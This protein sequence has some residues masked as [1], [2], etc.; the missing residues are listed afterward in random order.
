MFRTFKAFQKS[1]RSTHLA[2]VVKYIIVTIGQF[3]GTCVPLLRAG[4]N[5]KKV[6]L[7]PLMRYIMESY[8]NDPTHCTNRKGYVRTQGDALAQIQEWM[9]YQAYMKRIRNFAV[10]NPTSLL[11]DGDANK[12]TAKRI[13]QLWSAGPVHMVD[14]PRL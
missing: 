2:N 13:K 8:C 9:D 10:L 7:S 6:L 5:H 14:Q 11:D 3:L 12:A 4:G 1:I